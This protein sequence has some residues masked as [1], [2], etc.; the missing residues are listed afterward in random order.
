MATGWAFRI[1]IHHRVTALNSRASST[2]CCLSH[3]VAC[4]TRSGPTRM[5]KE[6]NVTVAN[7]RNMCADLHFSNHSC[8]TKSTNHLCYVRQWLQPTGW[9]IFWTHLRR[10][11]AP[12]L[13]NLTIHFLTSPHFICW[14]PLGFFLYR[15]D[16]ICLLIKGQICLVGW[17]CYIADKRG[18]WG[19][20]CE[21][22]RRSNTVVFVIL[23]GF[24][25]EIF[26]V[27]LKLG[28][29]YWALGLDD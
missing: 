8:S 19:R 27:I 22:F 1:Q 18:H 21:E 15:G 13:L 25:E 12:T 4:R 3:H 6:K 24:G 17:S 16:N 28:V 20:M 9:W 5:W 10:C 2:G 11:E 7:G 29:G 14:L 26:S 23:V